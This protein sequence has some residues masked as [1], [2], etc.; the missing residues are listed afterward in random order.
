[1]ALERRICAAK[2][3]GN[4]EVDNFDNASIQI[5][6]D[7]SRVDILVNDMSCMNFTQNICEIELAKDLAIEWLTAQFMFKLSVN[8]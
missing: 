1:V 3:G 8:V 5:E 2:L 4:A 6:D 7:V